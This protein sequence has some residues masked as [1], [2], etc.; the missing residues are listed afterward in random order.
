MTVVN[1]ER[2]FSS[3]KSMWD[4][5]KTSYIHQYP[6]LL[7][8]NSPPQKFDLNP[9]YFSF[10]FLKQAHR[11]PVGLHISHPPFSSSSKLNSGSGIR[12]EYRPLPLYRKDPSYT[13]QPQPLYPW[14]R[15]NGL[16]SRVRRSWSTHWDSSMDGSQ[17]GLHF[18]LIINMERERQSLSYFTQLCTLNLILKYVWF[19]SHSH[20][21]KSPRLSPDYLNSPFIS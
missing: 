8:D 10:L 6:S 16:K 7:S 4:F 13:P 3:S 18:S 14:V 2:K 19:P 20:C 5:P 12:T 21:N 9:R 15:S 1:V 17:R 11:F